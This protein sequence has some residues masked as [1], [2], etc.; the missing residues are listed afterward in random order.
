MTTP[1][2]VLDRVHL[3]ELVDRLETAYEHARRRLA[4]QAAYDAFTPDIAPEEI[5]D[6]TG[7]FLL[8][9]ALTALVNARTALAQRPLGTPVRLYPAER[10][11]QTAPG[12]RLP[13]PPEKTVWEGVARLEQAGRQNHPWFVHA[14]ILEREVPAG[15]IGD[16]LRELQNAALPRIILAPAPEVAGDV[17]RSLPPF[18]PSTI[19]AGD[20]LPEW[21]LYA[22]E[23]RLTLHIDTIEHAVGTGARPWRAHMK[24]VEYQTGTSW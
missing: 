4:E 5:R 7:R 18:L 12:T 10:P 22:D 20:P 23:W 24:V 13:A 15:R 6:S 8:L 17:D 16:S 11:G 21:L 1:Q 14:T 3:A 9:D 19:R 2:E